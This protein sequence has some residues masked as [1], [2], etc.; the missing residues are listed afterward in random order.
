MNLKAEGRDGWC[1]LAGGLSI[2]SPPLPTGDWVSEW[3]TW[4]IKAYAED[5]SSR[6][7]PS[8]IQDRSDQIPEK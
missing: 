1:K 7:N 8:L 2:M 5:L 6:G 4:L 3:P